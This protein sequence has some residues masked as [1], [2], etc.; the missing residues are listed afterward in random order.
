[1][2]ISIR[3]LSALVTVALA[4]G[5][6][7]GET[8]M[9]VAVLDFEANNAS[10]T[11]AAVLTELVRSALVNTRAIIL[12]DKKNMQ[13]IMAEQAFQQ[14]GCTTDGCAVK[15]GR[16]LNVRKIVM[17]N[18]SVLGGKRY[19]MARVVDV[20]TG[21]VEQSATEK[22]FDLDSADRAVTALASGLFMAVPSATIVESPATGATV[23]LGDTPSSTILTP[24]PTPGASPVA[25]GSDR[26]DYLFDGFERE[27]LW[28]ADTGSAATG[29]FLDNA[30]VSEG[31]HS[32][33]LTFKSVGPAGKAVYSRDASADWSSFGA[34]LLDIYNPTDLAGMR[35]G[36]VVFSSGRYLAHEY[37]TPPLVK[38]WNRN[39]RVD[40]KARCFSLASSEYNPTSYLTGRGDVKS[41][42]IIVYPGASA[43][44]EINI[45][46]I[47]LERAG[48]VTAG[49]L[50]V[51]TTLDLT[52]SAGKLDYLPTNMRI[53]ERDL[54]PIESFE[55][56]LG[57]FVSSNPGVTTGPATDYK[58]HGGTA[59][60]VSYPAAPD[61]F[62]VRLD[63][64]ENSLSGAGQL[65]MNIYCPGP[66]NMIALYLYDRDGND[67]YYSERW[68]SHGWNTPVFDFTNQNV[69]E[70]GVVDE[71]ILGNLQSVKLQIKSPVPGRLTIDGISTG[72]LSLKGAGRAG[73][74]LSASYNP[75]PNFEFIADYRGE[76]TAYGSNTDDIH[77][78]GAE[79]WLDAASAR[80]DA[81]GFRT[82]ALYRRRITPMDQ[83]KFTL[84]APWVLGN[85]IAG[86]ETAGA[87]LG[88]EVMALAASRLEYEEYNTHGPTGF[89]P[90]TAM[91]FRVRRTVAKA[92]RVGITH[93]TH[94]AKFG[95]GITEYPGR[96]F[97]WGSDFENRL[98][99]SGITVNTTL[100]GAV[101]TGDRTVPD[102]T[103][104]RRDNYFA[105]G[106]VAP[107]W[108]RLKFYYGFSRYGYYFDTDLASYEGSGWAGHTAE[109]SYSLEGL[110]PAR[111][112]SA[113]PIYD[114]SFGNNLELEVD[115][116]YWY[117]HARFTD[118]NGDM[119]PRADG[120]K[121]GIKFE[122]DEKARPNFSIEVEY[123]ENADESS[124]T[125][126]VEE[127]GSLRL[128]LPWDTAITTYLE[129]EQN[130]DYSRWTG[131]HGH[132]WKRIQQ[133]NL[134]KYFKFNLFLNFYAQW[135]RSRKSWEGVWEETDQR[136]RLMAGARQDLGPNTT[137][138]LQ[139]GAPAL[140]GYDFGLQTTINVWTLTL[141]SYF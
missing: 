61:G 24:A 43:E 57:G 126:L 35:C 74:L 62:F 118:I 134:E 114:R 46:N 53:R 111:A 21:K 29:R 44:G 15:L 22:G 89:G 11:D 127:K 102:P 55:G 131:E 122:N 109:V 40:L 121:A 140:L 69:W 5:V 106:S 34:L 94:L 60:E 16:L 28:Y 38:G 123:N 104:S 97:T 45:D 1:M 135:F 137:V 119:V 3:L 80:W 86:M 19:L 50:A 66:G 90:D 76:D 136:F 39:I 51:N 6:R 63:G 124:R 56:P 139:F 77:T 32:L 9:T 70:G 36:I 116:N 79:G 13:A 10:A 133:L 78:P 58:T 7:A 130:R 91:E 95:H 120:R 138:E 41:V 105:S 73:A 26:Y 83:P 129:W 75:S 110:A 59:L 108:E 31:R 17:G 93:L 23:L 88:C 27:T 101:T 87:A 33:K 67:P 81:G 12:V 49:P 71:S 4:G 8:D 65:R 72:R 125:P 98:E 2:N 68:V 92:T 37:I 14:T 117:T 82:R 85:N 115:G 100:E 42:Q 64:L 113:I 132:G 54:T 99:T 112:L 48:V 20:E 25:G 128:P 96:R 103:V 84:V 141:K 47:R 107:E 18:Y 30:S 52:A